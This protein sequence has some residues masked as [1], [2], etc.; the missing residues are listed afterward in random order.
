MKD[1]RWKGLGVKH[2]YGAKACSLRECDP[3]SE[4][5]QIVGKKVLTGKS[6]QGAE[7]ECRQ[8]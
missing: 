7:A 2:V 1:V 5:A 6:A 8:P 4:G 3:I